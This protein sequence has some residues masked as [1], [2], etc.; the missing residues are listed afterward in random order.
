MTTASCIIESLYRDREFTAFLR[1]QARRHF[2]RPDDQEDAIE[3]AWKRLCAHLSF[4]EF[5]HAAYCAIRNS[6]DRNHR[7]SKRELPTDRFS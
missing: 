5:K 3:E 7:H 4:E 6:Y 1:Q 2:S